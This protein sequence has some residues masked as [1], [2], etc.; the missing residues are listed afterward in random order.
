[1]AFWVLTW[2]VDFADGAEVRKGDVIAKHEFAGVE[3]ELLE[4]VER[5]LQLLAGEIHLE[6]PKH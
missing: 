1:M 6:Y 2:L 5:M 4:L 3:E